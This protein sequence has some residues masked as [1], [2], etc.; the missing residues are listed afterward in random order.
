MPQPRE[1][2][3]HS[4]ALFND[5]IVVAGGLGEGDQG[6]ITYRQRVLFVKHILLLVRGLCCLCNNE[7]DRGWWCVIQLKIALCFLSIL[8][9]LS[10][11]VCF[12]VLKCSNL[13]DKISQR[14]RLMDIFVKPWS[15]SKPLSQHTPKSN[16]SSQKRKKE[17]FGPGADS[18]ITSQSYYL[19]KFQNNLNLPGVIESEKFSSCYCSNL[20]QNSP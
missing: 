4:C 11:F 5:H 19:S 16:K 1:D 17:R 14:H 2:L 8:S 3:S 13:V 10:M 12:F 20:K 9:C 18:K 7:S 15:E 6:M